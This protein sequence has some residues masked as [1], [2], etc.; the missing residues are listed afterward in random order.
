CE[1]GQQSFSQ[2]SEVENSMQTHPREKPYRCVD[3]S[4][5]FGHKSDLTRHRRVHIGE[6]P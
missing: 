5:R 2:H 4:K 1:D 6:K 3:C